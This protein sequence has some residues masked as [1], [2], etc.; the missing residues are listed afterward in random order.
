MRKAT[1]PVF[2]SLLMCVAACA[3]TVEGKKIVGGHGFALPST[4]LLREYASEMQRAPL[5]GVLVAVN[6]ND[7]AGKDKLRDLAAP[8]WFRPPAVTIEDFS[9]ALE[10]MAKADLGQFKH[11]ILWCHGLRSIG[12]DLWDD[13]AWRKWSSTTRA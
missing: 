5:D 13:E 1:A 3:Q 8:L 11:N 4:H 2:L 6:R 9:I 10:D 7:L 12:G